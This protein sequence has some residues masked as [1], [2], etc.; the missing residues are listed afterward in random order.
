[1][2]FYNQGS[3]PA[4]LSSIEP[5]AFRTRSVDLDKTHAAF[6]GKAITF[7][8]EIRP[9][10]FNQPRLLWKKV[11]DNAAKDRFVNNVAG[12]MSTCRVEEVIKRQIAIFRE[13]SH[14]L[15]S[16][17]EQATGIKGYDGIGNLVF[18]GCHNGMGGGSVRVANGMEVSNLPANN[19]AP[20]QGTH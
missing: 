1:M 3:R 17:L 5:I 8:S 7:L 20:I 16:R 14:D 13:V 18:N 2:A 11:F 15:A 19:G 9:E 10:D 6:S 4:Y 12:H